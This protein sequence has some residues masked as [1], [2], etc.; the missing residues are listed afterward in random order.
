MLGA[1]IDS[2]GWPAC[3]EI[4]IMENIGAEPAIVHG[5]IHGPGYSG[6]NGIGGP[7]SLTGGAAFADDFHV[8][9]IEWKPTAFAGTWTVSNISR[10]PPT[11]SRM[12]QPGSSPSR[13]FSS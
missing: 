2:V 10:S 8:F 13:N 12:A 9:A 3:G 11:I 4:D 5:T 1:N 6:G 7:D